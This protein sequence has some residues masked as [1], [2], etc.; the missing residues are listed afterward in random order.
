[1]KSQIIISALFL[2]A[3]LS[4]ADP[5]LYQD[6]DFLQ[7]ANFYP[8][9]FQPGSITPLE[10]VASPYLYLLGR[11]F[12]YRALPSKQ[13]LTGN[14][15]KLGGSLKV[16]FA[17]PAISFNGFEEKSLNYAQAKSSLRVSQNGTWTRLD[18]PGLL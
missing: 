14:A 18:I 9:S 5:W 6:P 3:V 17:P 7:G 1:M 10:L 12:D 16:S 13:N 15:T 8:A 2:L 11:G 4:S